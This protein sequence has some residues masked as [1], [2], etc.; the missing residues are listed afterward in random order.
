MVW[1][2]C[3]FSPAYTKRKETLAPVPLTATL[4]ALEVAYLLIVP[5]LVAPLLWL[6]RVPWSRVVGSRP[7]KWTEIWLALSYPIPPEL[8]VLESAWA[9]IL[10][11]LSAA[12]NLFVVALLVCCSFLCCWDTIRRWVRECW[13]RSRRAV[14]A[15]QLQPQQH[16]HG[17]APRDLTC[18]SIVVNVRE[19]TQWV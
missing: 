14:Q 12:I 1:R 3:G 9:T 4:A 5:P 17:P 6:V 13:V 15:R 18:G 7:K 16:S 8:P 10:W 2:C 19:A 11:A